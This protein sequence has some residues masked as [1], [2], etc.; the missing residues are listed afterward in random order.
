MARLSDTP[1]LDHIRAESAR[2]RVVLADCDP[3][4]RVPSCPDWSADD[5]LWHLA[6]VQQWWTTVLRN[7]PTQPES[8]DPE[9]PGDRA[10]LLAFFDEWSAAL[11]DELE[12]ADPA[13]E[14]W[15]WSSDHTVGFI[16]RRQAHEALI[17]RLDAELAAGSVTP[18]DPVLASDGVDEVLD[19]MY[20]G[21][22]PWGTWEPLDH[23][24]RVDCTDTDQ[25]TWVRLG[26]FSGT[27][28]DGQE[29]AGEEDAHVVAD[30]GT[31]PDVVVNGT[32]DDL[33]AWLW[34]R[35]DDSGITH[36]GDQAIY[37]RF[38]ACVNHPID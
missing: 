38:L 31:A 30:P 7:R 27:S 11:S 34:R 13:E 20:G 2:F 15:T 3:A 8:V 23:H 5:L 32:A 16:L 1:Y 26:L 17:H 29:Y 6:G 19:V 14:C 4:A 24:V 36:A 12:Q 33:D 37:E 22:P 25:S 18:L 10:G 35:R 28:P 21:L 9:R